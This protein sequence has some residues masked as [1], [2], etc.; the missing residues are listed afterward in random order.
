MFAA[1]VENT[2]ASAGSALAAT[3]IP[4]T[5]DAISAGDWPC[6]AC[7]AYSNPPVEPRP[8][9]G[10]TL[11]GTAMPPDSAASFGRTRWIVAVALRLGSSRS[12]YGLRRATRNALFDAALPPMKSREMTAR[13]CSTAGSARR[14]SSTSRVTADVRFCDAPSG[15]CRIAKKAP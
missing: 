2:P 15:S 12:S 9:I 13:T 11:R 10:G 8:M 3:V 1:K 14:I 4:R 7:S 5:T 6:S